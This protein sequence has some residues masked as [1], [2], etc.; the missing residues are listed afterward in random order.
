MK[1]FKIYKALLKINFSYLTAYRSNLINSVIANS[2]WGFF[3]LLLIV[4]LTSKTPSVFGWTRDELF[5]LFGIYNIITSIFQFFFTR[6]FD[7][8]SEIINR[9]RLDSV[10]LKP[11]DSQFLMSLSYANFTVLL[12]AFFGIGFIAYVF[13]QM[14]Y[15]PTLVQVLFSLV[16][17]SASI[18]VLYSVWYI[19][20]TCLIW[21]PSFNN[22][23]G[24]MYEVN[25]TSRY[26][27]EMYRA[28]SPLLFY[29][30]L[31]LTLIMTVPTQVLIGNMTSANIF[32]L[33]FFALILFIVSRVFWKYALRFYTSVG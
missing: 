10:L 23:I 24:L 6:S 3:S 1:Y 21:W 5:L 28:I 8:F 20:G 19:V 22:L 29:T 7:R 15:V 25:G 27:Q 12:R 2:V 13:A 17:M 31:P 16:L 11:A 9:G 26:P 4:I 32:L 14:H 18:T 30:I 33:I